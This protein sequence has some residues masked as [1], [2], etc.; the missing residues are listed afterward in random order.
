MICRFAVVVAALVAAVPTA[1]TPLAAQAVI[2][3]EEPKLDPMRATL[4][5]DVLVLR[6]SLYAVD[7]TSA[8]LVRAKVGNSPSV[9]VSSARTLQSDCVRAARSALAMRKQMGTVGTNDPR[10]KAV[11]ADYNKGL[12]ELHRAMLACDKSLQTAL[13]AST[14][15]VHDTEPY[16]RTALASSEAIKKYD[17]RLHVLLKTLQIPVDPKGFRSAINM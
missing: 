3:G 15:K 8:R 9:V 11:I 6:D 12:D 17:W 1:V 10:G 4:K 5:A 2:F 13:V 14:A 16:F 7:A